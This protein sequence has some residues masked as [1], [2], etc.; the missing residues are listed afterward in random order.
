MYGALG[1]VN[2]VCLK[3]SLEIFPSGEECGADVIMTSSV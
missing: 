1:N 2:D 3:P